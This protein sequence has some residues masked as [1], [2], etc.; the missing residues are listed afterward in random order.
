MRDTRDKNAPLSQFSSK[1]KCVVDFFGPTDLRLSSNTGYNNPVGLQL[2]KDFIGKEPDKAPE[3]YADASPIT[4]VNKDAVPFL[5]VHGTAD[6]LVP[7]S[8]SEQLENALKK[9]GV[10]A[11]LLR[12]EGAGHGFGPL[13]SPNAQKA[14][15]AAV[16]FLTKHLKP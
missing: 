11:T 8:Q 6:T 10:E 9:A 14:W 15:Q 7:I 5:I 13:N 16:E 1:V 12:I 3:L 4:F 2:V